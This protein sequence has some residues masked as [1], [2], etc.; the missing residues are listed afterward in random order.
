MAMRLL[1]KE[2]GGLL[3]SCCC[4]AAVSQ[5]EGRFLEIIT[6]GSRQAQRTAHVLAMRSAAEDHPILPNYPESRYLIACLV[7]VE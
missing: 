1:D 5:N 4:S 6:K 7:G 2:A 3:L